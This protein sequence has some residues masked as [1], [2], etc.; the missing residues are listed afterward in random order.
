MST[1]RTTAVVSEALRERIRHGVDLAACVGATTASAVGIVNHVRGSDSESARSVLVMFAL[2]TCGLLG[3]LGRARWTPLAYV[4]LIFV[5]NV[6]FMMRYGTWFGLGTVY[7]LAVALAFAFH[8]ERAAWFTAFALIAT[9]ITLAVLYGTGALADQPTMRLDD[10]AT[11]RRT[12][13]AAATALVG[14]AMMSGY[15]VRQLRRERRA[16]ERALDRQRSERLE[17]ARVDADLLRVRRVELLAEL[18]AEVGAEIG[19]ALAVVE[20]R[21]QSLTAELRGHDAGD[22]LGDILEATANAGS[23]M[24]SLTVFAPDPGA[25]T[26][27]DVAAAMRALPKL[28]RR[29]IPDR[30]ALE[31]D[32]DGDAA[33]AIGTTD[34]SRVLANLVLNARDAIADVGAITVRARRGPATVILEVTDTGTGMTDDVKE[35]LFQPFFT[36]K[37]VGRGTGLGLATARGLVERARGTITV[38]SELGRGT[39]FTIQLP[40]LG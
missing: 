22:C 37:A 35:H 32:D 15:A 1:M 18:A 14:T 5:A 12:A 11:W 28:V 4:A 7:V 40:L 6:V 29:T 23:I 38:T 39:T 13:L 31:V 10:V 3:L 17:Q 30:I 27:G 16:M 9:P 2:A 33:V 25:V 20:A 34:L 21:A 36:T 26:R 24:R 8:G 19:A